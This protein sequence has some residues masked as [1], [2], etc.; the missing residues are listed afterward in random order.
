MVLYSSLVRSGADRK[1]SNSLLIVQVQLSSVVVAF[2][3]DSEIL[4]GLQHGNI[5][6]FLKTLL[7][8][9]NSLSIHDFGDSLNNKM[10]V[11][12]IDNIFFWHLID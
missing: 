5:Q 1:L 2:L 9:A 3:E 8:G 12:H 6:I 7:A 4:I 10:L 11:L